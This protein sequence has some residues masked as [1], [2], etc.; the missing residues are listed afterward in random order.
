MLWTFGT[1]IGIRAPPAVSNGVVFVGSL[2]GSMYA[3]DAVTGAKK[4]SYATGGMVQG[5][6]AMDKTLLYIGS[7][8]KYVCVHLTFSTPLPFLF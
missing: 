6:S 2:D 5:G 3:L 7:D 8:D 4:W 1:R